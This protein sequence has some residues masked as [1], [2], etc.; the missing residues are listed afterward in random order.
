MVGSRWLGILEELSLYLHILLVSGF[1]LHRSSVHIVGS[2]WLDIIR[3]V[4]S[5]FTYFYCILKKGTGGRL[6]ISVNNPESFSLGPR[7]S[8]HLGLFIFLVV[9]RGNADV[10]ACL[11]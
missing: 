8:M 7:I 5:A 1:V 4:R 10:Q 2:R 9:H 6:A 3:G 11:K